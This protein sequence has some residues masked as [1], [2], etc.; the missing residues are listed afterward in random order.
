P[1]IGEYRVEVTRRGHMAELRLQVEASDPDASRRL[2]Q[3]FAA[4]FS[5]RIPVV[6]VAENSLPRFELK[7]QRWVAH[8]S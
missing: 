8:A 7:A 1:E 2:E 4:A 3:A 6:W 5:L